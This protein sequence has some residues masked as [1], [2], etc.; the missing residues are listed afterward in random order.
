MTANRARTEIQK[1]GAN[2]EHHLEEFR[3]EVQGGTQFFYAM[4]AIRALATDNKN[5]L[6]T[7]NDSSLFWNTNIGALQT[8]FFVTLGRI[9]DQKSSYNV[10]TLLKIA[11]NHME[12]FS[13]T[14]LAE[15]KRATSSSADEW[16]P[17]YL[18]RVYEPSHDDF[19][20]MKKYLR[21]YRAIYQKNYNPIRNKIYAHKE[22]SLQSDKNLLFSQTRIPEIQKLFWFLNQLYVILWELYFNGKAPEIRRLPYSL[23]RMMQKENP[24][25]GGR[26]VQESIVDE[27]KKFFSKQV[28]I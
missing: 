15:R 6:A 9:F 27:V 21:K 20:C 24:G 13:K 5:I 7:L 17:Q 18:S 1:N 26:T 22:L 16:L 14:S 23:T 28:S 8:S 25:H 10:D 3:K 2:F 11:Q 19:R 4:L 12:I